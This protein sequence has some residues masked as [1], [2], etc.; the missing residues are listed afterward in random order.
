MSLLAPTKRS[1]ATLPCDAGLLYEILTDYDSYTEWLPHLGQSKALA[2][3]G[4]LAIAEF[5]LSGGKKDRLVVECI[6]T[7]NK[8]VLWRAIEGKVPVTQVEWTIEAAGPSQSRVSL[9]VERRF[10][11]SSLFSG[12]GRFLNPAAALKGLQGQVSTYLPEIA[13]AD[14]AGEKIL[15]ISETED[16]VVCWIRG[17][18]YVL[19]EESAA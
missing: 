18:K 13:L 9:A 15:E 16:G 17:K 19:K 12:V 3:E 5:H 2:T 14:E 11:W 1:S 7:R 6:H 10:P 4:D 8:M